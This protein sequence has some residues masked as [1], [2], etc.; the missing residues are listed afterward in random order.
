VVRHPAATVA[1]PVWR[2]LRI[3]IL[4]LILAVLTIPLVAHQHYQLGRT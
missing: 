4:L 1:L 3:A 2:Q